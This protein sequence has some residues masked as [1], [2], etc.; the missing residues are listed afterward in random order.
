M[1][2]EVTAGAGGGGGGRVGGPTGTCSGAFAMVAARALA[3]I[4]TAGLLELGGRGSGAC[5]SVT[6]SSTF[7]SISPISAANN[8]NS[9]SIITPTPAGVRAE[10]SHEMKNFHML[11]V[12]P[13]RCSVIKMSTVGLRL[14]PPPID[15][16]WRGILSF[17]A[18]LSRE[19]ISFSSFVLSKTP[20]AGCHSFVR[21]ATT[22]SETT[23]RPLAYRRQRCPRAPHSSRS[24]RSV[25]AR[26]LSP[27]TSLYSLRQTPLGI[28]EDTSARV[29][30]ITAS[31]PR[32]RPTQRR[33]EVIAA[34]L[35]SFANFPSSRLLLSPLRSARFPGGR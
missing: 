17:R 28:W 4:V 8:A 15:P 21:T 3:A 29:A 7:F 35:T 25:R 33:E 10:S 2:P 27:R 13:P 16:V 18:R 11:F 19:I 31:I 23:A 30:R 26:T 5:S 32:V 9:S 24:I 12:D 6:G 22:R 34:P 14:P 20:L 1:G